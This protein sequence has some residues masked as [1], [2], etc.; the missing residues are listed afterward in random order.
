[1]TF[2]VEISETLQRQVEIVAENE[3]DAICA[4]RAMYRNGE[5]VLSSIDHTETSFGVC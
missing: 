4:A 1:M 5:I 3:E 2:V